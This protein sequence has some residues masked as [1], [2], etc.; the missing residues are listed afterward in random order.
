LV[1]YLLNLLY[2]IVLLSVHATVDDHNKAIS[3]VFELLRDYVS[4]NAPRK[5]DGPAENASEDDNVVITRCVHLVEPGLDHEAVCTNSHARTTER[6]ANE[7]VLILWFSQ[8]TARKHTGAANIGFA[9]EL[10]KFLTL[11][12]CCAAQAAVAEAEASWVFAGSFE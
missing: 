5:T 7:T 11:F 3:N 12:V 8:R 1:P 6:L 10:Q 4:K 9:S 2:L